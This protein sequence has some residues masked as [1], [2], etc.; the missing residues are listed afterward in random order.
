MAYLTTIYCLQCKTYQKVFVGSN[1]YKVL[2]DD[3]TSKNAEEAHDKYRAELDDLPLSERIRR[4]EEW[5]YAY[6]PTYVEPPR[7]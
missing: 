7:F 5:I 1:S 3:C 6:K 4:V 2:C